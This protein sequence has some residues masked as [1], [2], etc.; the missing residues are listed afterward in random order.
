MSEYETLSDNR[1]R[2]LRKILLIHL[3]IS[4]NFINIIG[5]LKS[6]DLELPRN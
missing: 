2:L 5:S 3:I 1:T 4:L 6:L